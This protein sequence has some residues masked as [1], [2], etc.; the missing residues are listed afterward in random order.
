VIRHAAVAAVTVG[1]FGLIWSAMT[2]IWTRP[3][4]TSGRG[5]LGRRACACTRRMRAAALAA[6]RPA[7]GKASLRSG[8]GG[9]TPGWAAW[10][11]GER[12][13]IPLNRPLLSGS[14]KLGTP[15]SRIQAAYAA[16]LGSLEP[17]CES[18]PLVVVLVVPTWATPSPEE[19][20]QPAATSVRPTRAAV[21]TTVAAD[22]TPNLRP[23]LSRGWGRRLVRRYASS[24]TEASAEKGGVCPVSRGLQHRRRVGLLSACLHAP[25]SLTSCER[26]TKERRKS[27]PRPERWAV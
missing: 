8:R 21:A 20:L 4:A 5:M 22:R 3:F 23:C 2:G 15:F 10:T 14:G 13:S 17:L 1:A 11:A 12:L 7:G 9:G 6:A 19:P 25:A 27:P 18:A 16:G 24:F 26:I